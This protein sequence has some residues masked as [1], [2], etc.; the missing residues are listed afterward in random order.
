VLGQVLTD[1]PLKFIGADTAAV[2]AIVE[3]ADFVRRGNGWPCGGG[4]G[5]Q[6]AACVEGVRAALEAE[7]LADAQERASKPK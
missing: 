1:C 4:W 6:A 7:E 3:A 2:R 5:D